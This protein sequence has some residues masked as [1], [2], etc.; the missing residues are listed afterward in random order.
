ML[1]HE[2]VA[3]D[4]EFVT[5]AEGFELFFEEDS[6]VVGVEERP[7]LVATEGDEVEV[8]FVLPAF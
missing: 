8:P 3:V 1:G 6:G 2:D 5:E 4:V 7:A